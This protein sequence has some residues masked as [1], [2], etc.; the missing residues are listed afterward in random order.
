MQG[1]V[2]FPIRLDDYIFTGWNHYHKADVLAKNVEDF[3]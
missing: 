3:R 1:E 2:L